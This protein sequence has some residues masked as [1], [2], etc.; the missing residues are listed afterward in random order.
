MIRPIDPVTKLSKVVH[1]TCETRFYMCFYVFSCVLMCFP[2]LC[3]GNI[4]IT[5]AIAIGSTN[6]EARFIA[7]ASR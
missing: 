7:A 1:R 3:F 2:D 5:A 6:E 4:S